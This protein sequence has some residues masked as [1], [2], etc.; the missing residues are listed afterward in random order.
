MSLPRFRVVNR[1]LQLV[2]LMPLGLASAAE[3]DPRIS[4]GLR[5]VDEGMA[6]VGDPLQVV[7]WIEAPRDATAPILLAPASGS[8]S[9]AVRV[10]LVPAG[11]SAPVARAEPVGRPTD[12][13]ATLDAQRIAGG[14]WR[15]STE[16]TKGLAAGEYQVRVGLAIDDGAGWKGDAS[17]EDVPLRLVAGAE[18]GGG[19]SALLRAL[20]L[21]H[22]NQFEDAGR[23]LD[24]AL[25]ATPTSR[26]L[27]MARAVVAERAGNLPAAAICANAAEPPKSG[28]LSGYP[29]P[30]LEALKT[31]IAV[32]QQATPAE[33]AASPPAWTW[34]PF[35]VVAT[36]SQRSS[37]WMTSQARPP[38][39]GT[40]APA[41]R[42]PASASQPA[43][44]PG[45]RPAPP[46]NS[47][48]ASA[49]ER[50]APAAANTGTPTT[51]ASTGPGM[52]VADGELAE[53][54]ILA[55]PAGQWATGA[56][57]SSEYSPTRHTAAQATG[58]PNVTVAGD[59]T[60]AW[61]HAQKDTGSVWL[62][63]AFTRPVHA[64]EVRVRQN[65]AAGTIVR[66]EAIDTDG[67]THLWWEGT[68]PLV[69]PAVRQIHW[70]AV[71]VPKTEYQVTKI[72]I[73]LNLAAVRGW[74]QIDAVQLVGE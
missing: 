22:G 2:F 62:E 60:N 23:V 24:E 67:L 8:W 7:V 32:A 34:P 59:S 55:D 51:P 54:T 74:K 28:P 25:R 20:D 64:T 29:D 3:P 49:S 61:C 13:Q 48:S 72:R 71:R 33:G 65:N 63:V 30:E 57:A 26:E 11:G 42:A 52:L 53:A 39:A 10:E 14:L 9:D 19:N 66:I 38:T 40:V 16:A 17:A 46:P 35:E 68:D 18:G 58:A 37:A 56:T 6:S 47:P 21:M 50:A 5:G 69:P 12:A 4:A 1:I 41:A 36:L 73:T 15:F 27:L 44:A 31:R 45:T 70:F 43:P